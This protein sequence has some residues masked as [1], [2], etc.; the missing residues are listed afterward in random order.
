MEKRY[1]RKLKEDNKEKET[2]IYEGPIM[3]FGKIVAWKWEDTTQAVSPEKALNNLRFKAG[4]Y[5]G[6][7]VASHHVNIELDS[8][9]LHKVENYDDFLSDLANINNKKTCD[10]CGTPLNDGGTCPVC[11]D[12]EENY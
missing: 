4:V 7:N 3:R 5:L 1:F 12:G 6:L 10:K 8:K 9:Y 2:Y 11:D